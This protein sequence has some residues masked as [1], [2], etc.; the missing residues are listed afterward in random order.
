LL[1]KGRLRQRQHQE[2]GRDED[3]AAHSR[4]RDRNTFS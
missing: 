3:F 4:S 1:S 2:H